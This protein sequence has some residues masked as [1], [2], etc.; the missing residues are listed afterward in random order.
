LYILNQF[1]R[2]HKTMVYTTTKRLDKLARYLIMHL[3]LLSSIG[4]HVS[5]ISSTK[6]QR[7]DLDT[8]PT[9]PVRLSSR[10]HKRRVRNPSTVF[11]IVALQKQPLV[12]RHARKI[13][14]LCIRCVFDTRRLASAVGIS[15]LNRNNELVFHGIAAGESQ[16]VRDDWS[17]QGTPY[18]NDA[19]AA[20]EEGFSFFW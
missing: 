18:V 3:L 14:P 13:V 6:H 8:V 7:S 9:R 4:F 20:F 17:V 11:A 2:V 16:R 10:V 1:I 15:M 5:S 12:I 19:V